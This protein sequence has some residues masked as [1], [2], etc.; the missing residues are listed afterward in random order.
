MSQ[1]NELLKEAVDLGYDKLFKAADLALDAVLPACEAFDPDDEG[2]F[3]LAAVIL[4]AIGADGVLSAKERTFMK[5]LLDLDDETVDS[6]IDM[7]DIRLA[8]IADRFADSMDEDVKAHV[9]SFIIAILACDG[10]VSREENLFIRKII[11]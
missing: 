6:V 10:N 3:L 9:A 5:E 8:D 2:A 1:L 11:N 7:Y 4:S